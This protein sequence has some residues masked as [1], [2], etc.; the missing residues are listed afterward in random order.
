MARYDP[1]FAR[2]VLLKTFG[3]C[4]LALALCGCGKKDMPSESGSQLTREIQEDAH[5][6]NSH[7]CGWTSHWEHSVVGPMQLT[8]RD[9]IFY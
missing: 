2:E 8:K 1:G 4:L 3:L 9:R 5:R 7:C 6:S